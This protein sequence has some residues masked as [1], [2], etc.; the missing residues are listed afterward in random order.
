MDRDDKV[1]LCECGCGMKTSII[2]RSSFSEG[3]IKGEHRRFVKGHSSKGK[4]G[5]NHPRWNGGVARNNGYIRVLCPGH[6]RANKDGYVPEQI[7]IAEKALEHMLPEEAV[8]HH[9]DKVKIHNKGSN[10]VICENESYHQLIHHRQRAFEE[11]GDAN[12]RKCHVC[13]RYDLLSNMAVYG[14]EHCHRECQNRKAQQT[15]DRKKAKQLT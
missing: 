1:G 13:H 14:K 5:P 6:P 8:V 12:K 4:G 11:S 2:V 10:L 7:L 9:W 3:L 15:R